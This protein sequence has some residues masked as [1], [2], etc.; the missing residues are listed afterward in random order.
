[1]GYTLRAACRIGL[2]RRMPRI[3]FLLKAALHLAPKRVTSKLLAPSCGLQSRPYS[4]RIIVSTDSPTRLNTMREPSTA[5]LS[6]SVV[7]RAENAPEE[8]QLWR[9]A[10]ETRRQ[11]RVETLPCCSQPRELYE[12]N[13]V[14]DDGECQQAGLRRRVGSVIAHTPQ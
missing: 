7:C 5:H 9:E 3:R 4:C 6:H 12:T 2:K 14:A 1:M 11:C 10:G 8:S 13:H